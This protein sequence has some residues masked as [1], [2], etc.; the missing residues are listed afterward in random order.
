V[1]TGVVPYVHD[2]GAR[3]PSLRRLHRKRPYLTNGSAPTL[4]DVLRAVRVA[5]A[6]MSHGG[7]PA[8][9]VPLR[10]DERAAL[11]AFLDLL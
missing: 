6:G 8:G 9:G 7:S 1:R 5:P 2:E 10:E 4:D 11:R 3:T